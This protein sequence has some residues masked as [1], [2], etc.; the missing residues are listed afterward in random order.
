MSNAHDNIIAGVL[1]H[2][3]TE[4]EAE[5]VR[6]RSGAPDL[7][8][9]LAPEYSVVQRGRLAP[10]LERLYLLGRPMPGEPPGPVAAAREALNGGEADLGVL[11]QLLAALVAHVEPDP[12]RPLAPNEVITRLERHILVASQL[13]AGLRGKPF[14]W[15]QVDDQHGTPVVRAMGL[16]L[17]TKTALK[18][19]GYRPR[20]GA[21]PVGEVYYGAPISDYGQVYVMECQATREE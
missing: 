4:E 15:R 2:L 10:A 6:Q 18:R 11:R 8:E 1:R 14:Q 9:R 7:L 21:Q 12:P 19:R 13:K 17:A 3:L 20:R 16:T 5:Q